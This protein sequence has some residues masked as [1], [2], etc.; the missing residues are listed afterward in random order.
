MTL[1]E[2]A[3]RTNPYLTEREIQRYLRNGIFIYE[4]IDDFAESLGGMYSESE[5]ENLWM[6]LDIAN[7]DG[8]L[9]RYDLAL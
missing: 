4:D 9:Y 7:I 2:R 8:K 3:L 5:V 1:E 6:N